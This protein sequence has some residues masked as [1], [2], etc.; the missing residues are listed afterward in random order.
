MSMVII[1]GTLLLSD[2]D[3]SDEDNSFL[4]L[5]E[6]GKFRMLNRLNKEEETKTLLRFT[7]TV[8]L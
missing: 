8:L 5:E 7:L 2:F 3:F 4:H 1:S 6:W